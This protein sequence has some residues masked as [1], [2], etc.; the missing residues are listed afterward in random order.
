MR[1][2]RAIHNVF[3]EGVEIVLEVSLVVLVAQ[4][5]DIIVVDCF[6]GLEPHRRLVHALRET[7]FGVVRPNPDKAVLDLDRVHRQRASRARAELGLLLRRGLRNPC[8]RP[9][10]LLELPAVIA[11]LDPTVVAHAALAHRRETVRAQVLTARPHRLCLPWLCPH[12]QRLSQKCDL[13]GLPKRGTLFEAGQG[14]DR[15]PL[16]LPVVVSS[17]GLLSTRSGRLIIR[18]PGSRESTRGACVPGRWPPPA[19]GEGRQPGAVPTPVDGCARGGRARHR[20]RP[21]HHRS[22]CHPATA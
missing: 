14:P 6:Q 12:H 15:I 17:G 3:H 5:L 7:G 22:R 13:D 9:R 16:A 1:H 21:R 4:G 2:V 11:A 20:P 10:L 8:A 18:P 19:G